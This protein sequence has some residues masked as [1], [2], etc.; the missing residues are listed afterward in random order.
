[1]SSQIADISEAGPTFFSAGS[2]CCIAADHSVSL[3]GL[4][5]RKVHLVANLQPSP[6]TVIKWRPQEDF[7][8][9]GCSDGSVFVWETTSGHM[10]RFLPPGPTAN[11]ALSAA[12]H[13]FRIPPRLYKRHGFAVRPLL[14]DLLDIDARASWRHSVNKHC[15][16]TL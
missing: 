11:S 4:R 16:Y 8:L 15:G 7:L 10:D 5:D 6:I 12:E 13:P 1:M 9:V 14:L 3:V 2:V